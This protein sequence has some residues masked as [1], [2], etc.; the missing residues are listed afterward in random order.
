M[1]RLDAGWY[2]EPSSY[3]GQYSNHYYPQYPRKS[4]TWPPAPSVEDE[5]IALSREYPPRLPT[6]IDVQSRGDLEQDP[7]L[8]ALENYDRRFVLVTDPYLSNPARVN[9]DSLRANR[10]VAEKKSQ[11]LN[12]DINDA[13][14]LG[15]REPSPY[16]YTK[17]GSHLNDGDYLQS[18]ESFMP[19]KQS[20][21]KTSS[22]RNDSK[23]STIGS[24]SSTR[25]SRKDTSYD[26]DSSTAG[27]PSR[28]SERISSSYSYNPKD[29]FAR[30]DPGRLS[31]RESL[32]SH[33]KSAAGYFDH[34]GTQ[35]PPISIPRSSGQAR[36]SRPGSTYGQSPKQDY[37]RPSSYRESY[38]GPS[39]P[40]S[41]LRSSTSSPRGSRPSSPQSPSE[42]YQE[43]EP[44]RST[45]PPHHYRT[46]SYESSFRDKDRGSPKLSHFDEDSFRSPSALKPSFAPK[47]SF[48][49][50]PARS[51][52]PYPD[53]D[54]GISMPSEQTFQAIPDPVMALKR[55][56][57]A[58][59]DSPPASLSRASS[60]GD[61]LQST[62]NSTSR[63]S[64]FPMKRQTSNPIPTNL[65]PCPRKEYGS[66]SNEWSTLQ[67]TQNFS[68]CSS[69]YK[70]ILYPS[71]FRNLV[72][73][74]P[75]LPSS[76]KIRCDFGSPWIR[77]AWL[78]TH[79]Q[80]RPDLDLVYQMAHIA[81]VQQHCPEE[82]EAVGQWFGLIDP[83]SGTGSFIPNFA[84]CPR[85][86]LYIEIL[87]PALTGL[88][89]PMVGSRQPH[90][91]AVR[92]KS[93]LF[94]TYLDMLE[95]L[96]EARV[97]R[98]AYHRPHSMQYPGAGWGSG[99]DADLLKFISLVKSV[100]E[101]AAPKAQ[102]Q[103]GPPLRECKKDCIL[104]DEPWHYIPSFPDF[105]VCEACYHSQVL[106][107][108]RQGVALA[109]EFNRTPQMVPLNL[110][111]SPPVEAGGVPP[112]SHSCQLYSRRMRKVWERAARED[113]RA[114][115]VKKVGERKRIENDLRVKKGELERC[116]EVGSGRI[117]LDWVRRELDRVE[118]DWEDWE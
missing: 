111:F 64:T 89:Q 78:L 49:I 101:A 44:S 84:I 23:T 27:R 113:D 93:T 13:P 57:A 32:P 90:T 70:G 116:L 61:S 40:A 46:P 9:K 99:P 29:G 8:I 66:F 55:S 96:H 25:S 56:R 20:T 69:C 107:L 6:P 63:S 45:A 17:Q 117:D 83:T 1:A 62:S 98:A 41:P 51:T 34:K 31:P 105:T 53:D 72:L 26:S 16:A 65:P 47:P 60:M 7:I 91:C 59:Y 115:L 77:A 68:I 42:S 2:Y 71:P 28:K 95:D 36:T 39:P 50:R 92:V 67:G 4:R 5:R 30:T 102:S 74:H 87:F 76:A 82:F 19:K 80:N 21:S 11:S 106:P 100:V 104:V 88:F 108:A 52:L 35:S 79:N 109:I 73:P 97:S 33:I 48:P 75:I 10:P 118:R 14:F 24:Q 94:P 3:Y 18:P 15:R 112:N 43:F 37:L 54:Q 58:K 103:S 38:A 85:D 110:A 12:L 81:A 86:K 114:Y 22:S